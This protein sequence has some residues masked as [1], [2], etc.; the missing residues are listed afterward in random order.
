RSN[1]PDES[2]LFSCEFEW[3]DRRPPL[4][5]NLRPADRI[6]GVRRGF[7][8]GAEPDAAASDGAFAAIAARMPASSAV[9]VGGQPGTWTSTGITFAIRPRPAWLQPE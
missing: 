7:A 3:G 9:G 1:A 5:A 8:A 4:T 2:F 6:Q